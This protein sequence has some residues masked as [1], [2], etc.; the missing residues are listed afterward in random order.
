M[1]FIYKNALRYT[2]INKSLLKYFIDHFLKKLKWV[3][4][5][6]IIILSKKKKTCEPILAIV[7]D[8]LINRYTSLFYFTPKIPLCFFY[9][10]IQFGTVHPLPFRYP[11]PF[12]ASKIPSDYMLMCT[13]RKK[14][15]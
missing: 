6:K 8:K 5:K 4:F 13:R 12:Y 1:L 11:S 3:F 10:Q 14:K 7:K 9:L 15:E 2:T